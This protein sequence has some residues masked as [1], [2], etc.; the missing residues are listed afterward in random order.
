MT[1]FDYSGQWLG[2]SDG[3]PPGRMMLD[4]DLD[5]VTGASLGLACLFSPDPNAIPSSFAEIKFE[6]EAPTFSIQSTPRPFDARIGRVLT[7]NDLQTRFKEIQFPETVTI[8]LTRHSDDRLSV[9]WK[10]SIGTAGSGDLVR[11]R[12]TKVSKRPC[13]PSISSWN[14]FKR[15]VSDLNF[16]DFIFRGQSEPFPL[17]TTFHRSKRKVLPLY[18]NQ[19]IQ[20][21]YRSITG[22][23]R[24]VFNLDRPDE[25][26]A[27][28][29]LAQHHGFP[30]PLLDWTYSPFVAAWFAFERVGQSRQ[31]GDKVRI[32][33]IN[34]KE[35]LTLS[36]FQNL[37][38]TLPHVSILDALAIENDRAVPQQGLLMLTN[39]QDVEAHIY[40][41]EQGLGTNLLT[42]FDLP[43]EDAKNAMNDLAMMGITRSTLMPGIE[44]ICLDLKDRL[45]S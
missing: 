30:T 21:L 44:S 22:R 40:D 32:L 33:S 1:Y 7:I 37:T 39:P 10:T 23:I 34:R 45:F 4:L 19:D 6:S 41:L 15:Y 18:L 11:S 14:E 35:F 3:D 28:L 36:Q 43:I 25:L 31:S 38:F 5:T 12:P 29:N 26:G 16:R 24:H 20:L 27:M 17:Q 9:E 2:Y 13:E 8:H 42:A